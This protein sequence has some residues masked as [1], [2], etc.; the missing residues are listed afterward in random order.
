M[1]D[2]RGLVDP[3]TAFPTTGKP[4]FD[5]TLKDMLVSLRSSMHTDMLQCVNN[6]KTEMGALGGRVN[7][8]EEK[9]GDFASSHNTLIDAHIDHSEELTWLRSKVA[10]LEDR[11]RRNNVKIRGVPETVLPTQLQQ[12]AHDLIKT[13]L[14]AISESEIH[15]DRIHRLPKP[16]HLPDNILR[17]LMS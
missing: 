14:P 8:I 3:F 5:T 12:Y 4:V 17:V 1:E 15:V 6:F 11:S 7:H 10:D 13:L 2:T 16:A 9:M